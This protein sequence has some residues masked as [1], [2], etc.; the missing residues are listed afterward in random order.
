MSKTIYFD[1]T[2]DTIVAI[3]AEYGTDPDSL[4]DEVG[5]MLIQKIKEGDV[6]FTCENM[7]DPEAGSHAE[8]PIEW[9]EDY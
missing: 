6:I 2:I 5:K 9:Y 1:F 7:F 4:T 3:K 8:V